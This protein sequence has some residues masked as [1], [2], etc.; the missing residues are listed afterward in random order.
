MYNSP[1][2]DQPGSSNNR[3]YRTTQKKHDY[4]MKDKLQPHGTVQT[5]GTR[6]P[7]K[8]WQFLKSSKHLTYKS[9]QTPCNITSLLRC[10]VSHDRIPLQS[11]LKSRHSH[12]V[13]EQGLGHR[14]VHEVVKRFKCSGRHVNYR[15]KFRTNVDNPVI[16]HTVDPPHVQA[17]VGSAGHSCVAARPSF[18]DVKQTT[19]E[20]EKRASPASRVGITPHHD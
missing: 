5:S 6:N 20:M 16:D 8:E 9:G 7:R 12:K 11:N 14:S 2:L 1:R 17:A 19:D 3:G 13:K 15:M 10:A 18:A 4:V